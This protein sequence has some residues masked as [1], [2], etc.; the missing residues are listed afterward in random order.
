LNGWPNDSIPGAVQP[1]PVSRAK[2]DIAP[3]ATSVG[4][5][6]PSC[7]LGQRAESGREHHVCRGLVASPGLMVGFSRETTIVN[8]NPPFH[9]LLVLWPAF[10]PP[11]R[12]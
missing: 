10:P 3:E 9:G 4:F 12:T 5:L 1:R 6:I 8:D 2:K 7:G 11:M